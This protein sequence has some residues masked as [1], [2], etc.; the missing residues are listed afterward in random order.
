MTG[1]Q[2][3]AVAALIVPAF[4][5]VKE[6][7][8][9]KGVDAP[10]PEAIVELREARQLIKSEIDRLSDHLADFERLKRFTLLP[11][12]FSMAEGELT[13]T[14]KI[15]RKVVLEHFREQVQQMAE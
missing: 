4:D 9:G 12:E 2:Q 14:L 3:K 1:D 8:S 10:T 15:K 6:A 13:P 7:L 11:R 5:A